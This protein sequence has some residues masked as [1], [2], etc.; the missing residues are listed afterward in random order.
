MSVFFLS[1]KSRYLVAAEV[2]RDIMAPEAVE[3]VPESIPEP[4][5]DAGSA[6][7]LDEK[8]KRDVKRLRQEKI[9]FTPSKQDV[10]K[11]KRHQS[12]KYEVGQFQTVHE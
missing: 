7:T 8:P 1:Q 6:T 4:V 12:A 11:F 9:D 10:R 2:R 3:L 5:L